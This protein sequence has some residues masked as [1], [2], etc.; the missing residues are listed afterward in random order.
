MKFGRN[1][2]LLIINPQN[3]EI[4]IEPPFTLHFSVER[5]NLATANTGQLELTNLGQSTRNRIY[6]DRFDDGTKWHLELWAGYNTNLFK[7]LSGSIKEAYSFKNG[8][9]WKTT[10]QV[11][12]GA[13][14]FKNGFVSA[15]YNAN[16]SKS[17]LVKEV[18]NTLPGIKIGLLGSYAQGEGPKRAS[19]VFGPSREVLHYLVDGHF[20]VDNE[21]CHVLADFEYDGTDTIDLDETQLLQTP[22]RSDS[23]LDVSILF[24]PQI[25]VSISAILSSI[26]PIYNGKY[27]ISGFHHDVLISES[28]NGKAET[29]INLYK[30]GP[31]GEAAGSIFKA[32]T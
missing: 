3:E 29:R 8:T 21:T 22:Q 20:F 16:T 28:E 6:K 9:D 14:A 18:I 19:V 1:Y 10:I 24:Y 13:D 12:D 2:R 5:N 26:Y 23:G 4:T 25:R 11:Y 31:N 27:I 32:I 30:M 15:T 7:V 17:D